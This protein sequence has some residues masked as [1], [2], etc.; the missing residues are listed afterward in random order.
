[1]KDS[2]TKM[3]AG[4]SLHRVLLAVPESDCHVVAC[5]LLQLYLERAGYEVH[6]L[7]ATTPSVD[8][9][10]AAERCHPIAILL[11]SQNGHAL[12]D[13][14]NLRAELKKRRIAVPVYLGG[15][16][17]V[18]GRTSSEIVRRAFQ[19]IG[20]EVLDSFEDAAQRLAALPSGN[21]NSVLAILPFPGSSSP[22]FRKDSQ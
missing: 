7:G 5:K 22:L 14:Q 9:A 2:I 15:N 21:I 17:T 12:M 3:S 19:G 1:M 8:I 18:G 16:L 4:P 20:I 6:N 10:D 13:L 11:S